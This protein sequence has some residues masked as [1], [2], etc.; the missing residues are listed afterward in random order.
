MSTITTQINERNMAVTT[1]CPEEITDATSLDQLVQKFGDAIVFSWAKAQA[2][3][4]FRSSVRTKAMKKIGGEGENAG[5]YEFSAEEIAEMDW[6]N[7]TPTLRVAKSPVD[8]LTEMILKF[9]TPEAALA[10][11]TQLGFAI[12]ESKIRDIFAAAAQE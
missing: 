1:P 11:L 3:I 9:K 7:W 12:E 4:A 10:A 5:E 6:A 8:A 2:V